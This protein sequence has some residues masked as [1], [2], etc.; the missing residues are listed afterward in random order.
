MDA[1]FA[2]MGAARNALSARISALLRVNQR[3]SL[4]VI[5]AIHPEEAHRRSG[6][7]E[8]AVPVAEG[9]EEVGRVVAAKWS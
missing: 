5:L 8:I 2:L 6:V 1:D 7:D 9:D 4:Y 3:A